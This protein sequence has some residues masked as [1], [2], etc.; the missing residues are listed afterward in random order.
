[1]RALIAA[2]LLAN[3]PQLPGCSSAPPIGYD[4]WSPPAA[5]GLVRVRDAVAGRY[6]VVLKPA[7]VVGALALGS[8]L[9]L[10]AQRYAG[11]AEVKEFAGARAFAARASE[12]VA[13]ALSRDPAVAFVQEDG[14]KSVSPLSVPAAATWALD[15]I[16]QRAL[17]LDGEFH[18]GADGEGL[19]AYVIDT[20]CDSSHPEFA[21]RVGEGF[22][23]FGG[24]PSDGHGHGTHVAGSVLGARYGVAKRATLHCVQVL[25]A[26]GQGTDSDVVRGVDWAAADCRARGSSCAANMS[27]GGGPS[28]ALDQAVCRAISS[29][30]AVAVAAGNDNLN[31]CNYSPSRVVQALTTGASDRTDRSASFSNTGGCVDLYG[32]GVDVESA[33]PGG[34]A[35]TYSGTSMA[36]PHVAGVEVLCL[37]RH[38]GDPAAVHA[39]VVDR[40]SPGKVQGGTSDTTKRLLFARDQ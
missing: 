22:S 30:L 20:G 7:Q 33:A 16:D 40:A 39:C 11:L 6:I 23:S 25:N 1:M 13:L 32:P 17:P 14:R 26:Q 27:L 29:G 37:E 12:T 2:A 15:R 31:A 5:T 10:F 8:D 34:G 38:A 4:C 18:P 19:H 3:L 24:Q 9:S 35:A 28:P 36:S 21:G